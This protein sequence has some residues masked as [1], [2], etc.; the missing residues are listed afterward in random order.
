M[1]KL[2]AVAAAAALTFT[3][4]SVAS[5]AAPGDFDFSAPQTLATG[6][7]VPWGLAFLPDGSALVSERSSA[8]VLQ[9]TAD[10]TVTPLFTLPGVVVDFEDGLLGLAVS[11][12]Y[13]TDNYVYAFYKSSTDDRIVRF[14]LDTPDQQEPVLTGLSTAP[15][16]NGGRIAFG[17]DGKLY[18]GVGDATVTAN[19]QSM[20]SNNG[21]ILRMNADGTV[22]D[23]NPFPGSLIYSLGHRNVQGL[24]WDAQGRLWATEFGQSTWDEINLIRAGANYGWPTVEGTSTDARF[25]NPI[26]QWRPAD[27]SPSGAAIA[28]D[29]LFVASLRGQRLWQVPLAGDGTL[30]TGVAQLQRT[31][32][33]LRTVAVAPDGHLWVMTSMRDGKLTPGPTDDR[34]LR[35]PPAA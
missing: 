6:L 16:H 20:T 13:A 15:M 18:A 5:A 24:A 33:R 25:T 17:P 8:R 34:I 35:F 23:D 32:G 31:Y 11:P 21:K 14:R 19:S 10:G 12:D 9:V 1:R 30:G 2:I 29:N 28:G 26:L 7:A 22:P 27:A 4:V 3:G